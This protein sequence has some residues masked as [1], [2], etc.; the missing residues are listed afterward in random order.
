MTELDRALVRRKLAAITRNLDDLGAVEGLTLEEFRRD[1][2]RQKG[3]ERLLQE[4]VEAAADANV[5]LVRALG[6]PAPSDYYDSFVQ[7][8]VHGV[9]QD[10]L[11]RRL[12]PA[13]GLRNRLVHQYEAIDDAIVL[14]AVAGARR[15]F[16]E[17]VAAV[18]AYL[19]RDR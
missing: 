13:A 19:G 9:I 11:A 1:R 6:Q 4:I 8:G 10:S 15:D 17:Y 14:G 7:M 12:A 2:F 16:A 3:S 18:E 5:H